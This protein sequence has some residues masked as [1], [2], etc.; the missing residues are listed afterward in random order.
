MDKRVV[1]LLR[2]FARTQDKVV[3]T[4][5]KVVQVANML[6][7]MEGDGWAITNVLS[8]VPL[9]KRY[10]DS[11]CGELVSLLRDK[12]DQ[13]DCPVF[14]LYVGDL[15]VGAQNFALNVFL[16]SPDDH[17]PVDYLIVA[18]PSAVQAGYLDQDTVSAMVAA[19][20]A[21]AKV[22]PIA[23]PEDGIDEFV[24][25]GTA[26][27][28]IIG[29]DL[30]ALAEVGK[31]FDQA[32]A[33]PMIG[34]DNPNAGCEEIHPIIRLIKEYGPC[35]APIAPRNITAKK[36][37]LEGEDLDRHR[38]QIESKTRRQ[39]AHAASLGIDSLEFFAK[40]VMEEF[41]LAPIPQ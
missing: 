39:L 29:W 15:F 13:W 31:G 33:Q 25:R 20:K 37:V 41:R 7:T 30:K 4:A 16:N 19:F 32:A 14:G 10:K 26:G 38:K 5:E 34:G 23:V 40:G 35:Y 36:R 2:T 27:G 17:G 3:G 11:D 9:D 24:A 8:V 1:V 22:A 28:P 6:A 12:L 21:G 18:A